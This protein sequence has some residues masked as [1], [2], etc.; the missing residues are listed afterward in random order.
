[1]LSWFIKCLK[2]YYAT[3]QKIAWSDLFLHEVLCKEEM[4]LAFIIIN[5]Y[6]FMTQYFWLRLMYERQ[7]CLTNAYIIYIEY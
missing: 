3:K 2:I 1:M 4:V 7:C 5:Y 6:Y